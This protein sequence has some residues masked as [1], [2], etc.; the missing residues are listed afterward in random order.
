M[1]IDSA[2]PSLGPL[3]RRLPRPPLPSRRIFWLLTRLWLIGGVLTLSLVALGYAAIN[4]QGRHAWKKAVAQA[5]AQGMPVDFSDLLSPT[6]ADEDNFAAHPLVHELNEGFWQA[7]QTSNHHDW[8]KLNNPFATP[9]SAPEQNL[10]HRGIYAERGEI[11]LSRWSEAAPS[12]EALR[13]WIHDLQTPLEQLAAAAARPFHN[14]PIFSQGYENLGRCFRFELRS[15]YRSLHLRALLRLEDQQFERAAED[16]ISLFRLAGHLQ[17]TPA[18]GAQINARQIAAH[19]LNVVRLGLTRQAWSD[20]QL[21]RLQAAL[22]A[23]YALPAARRTYVT[24]QTLQALNYKATAEDGRLVHA[25]VIGLPPAE[26]NLV[27]YQLFPPSWW[28]L[29]LGAYVFGWQGGHHANEQIA[30]LLFDRLPRGPN[31]VLEYLPSGIWRKAAADQLTDVA[32]HNDDL[33]AFER[34]PASL[35]TEIQTDRREPKRWRPLSHLLPNADA[36]AQP[37]SHTRSVF[38]HQTQLNL[39]RTALLLERWRLRHG[40]YPDTLA[41]LARDLGVEPPQDLIDGQPLRYQPLAVGG[42]Q[43]YSIGENRADDGG[44]PSL[45]PSYTANDWTW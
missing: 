32:I 24:E 37:N 2:L 15:A 25:L 1:T 3:L 8:E 5:R 42:Y 17:S 31:Q 35:G 38:Y 20:Q 26:Q 27:A 33:L 28:P 11:V 7:V 45:P 34:S 18:M 6:V 21:S 12:P 44:Q 16:V 39:A 36:G 23:I 41:A 43:L 19:G 13:E 22:G 9:F 10:D 29:E 14:D 4:W 40:H 30:R